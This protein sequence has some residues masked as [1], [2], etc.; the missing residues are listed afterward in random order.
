V[1]AGV[2]S[3]ALLFGEHVKQFL[4]IFAGLLVA[5]LTVAGILNGQGVPYFV[6][7]VGGAAFHLMFQLRNLDINDVN[8]CLVVVR[9]HSLFSAVRA[10]FGIT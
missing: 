3:T 8:I 5:C 9:L 7:T 2:K 6:L 10:E 1:K 4:A